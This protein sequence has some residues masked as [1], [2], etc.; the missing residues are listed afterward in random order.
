MGGKEEVDNTSPALTEMQSVKIQMGDWAW[1]EDTVHRH[2]NIYSNLVCS[3]I[4]I[5][6]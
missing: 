1:E 5:E 3:V 4:G 6:L 2:C